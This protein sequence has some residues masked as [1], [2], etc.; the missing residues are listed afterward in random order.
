M[1][2]FFFYSK[3]DKTE[4]LSLRSKANPAFI[5]LPQRQQ[6]FFTPILLQF[7]IKHPP[8]Y[9]TFPALKPLAQRDYV[10]NIFGTNT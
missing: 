9:E 3:S 5:I 10:N 1:Q 8:Y 7:E 4:T 2:D 6:S